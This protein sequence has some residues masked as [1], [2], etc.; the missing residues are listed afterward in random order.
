[1]VKVLRF[2]ADSG[3]IKTNDGDEGGFMDSS[4]TEVLYE[5][6]GLSRY[7]VRNFTGN[8]LNYTSYQDMENG[9]WI[10]VDRDRGKVRRNR[11]YRRLVM[12]PAVYSEGPED[13]DFLYIKNQ[14]G[15]LQKDMEDYLDSQLHVHKNGAFLILDPSKNFK[16][17]FP[18][19]KNISDIVLQMNAYIVSDLGSG[20]LTRREDETILVSRVRFENIIEQVREKEYREMS[21]PKLCQEVIEYMKGFHMIEVMA[22]EKEIKI[23]PL[24]GK[25]IGNYPKSYEMRVDGY[26]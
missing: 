21:L 13:A 4:E 25:I 22:A 24:V 23:M 8:I 17:V 7:F 12:S 1:M 5:S 6:T 9:E 19:R 11:V 3:I 16:E 26:E 15:M 20:E 14:R 10:D 18:A 2:A